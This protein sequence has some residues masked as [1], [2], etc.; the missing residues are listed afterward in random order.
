MTICFDFFE[1]FKNNVNSG[2]V[3]KII[4]FNFTLYLRKEKKRLKNPLAP[5]VR[6]FATF[7]LHKQGKYSAK[8]TKMGYPVLF[9]G[10]FHLK[11]F[12]VQVFGV[13]GTKFIKIATKI[14]F[15]VAITRRKLVSSIIVS[16]LLYCLTS[17]KRTSFVIIPLINV[18]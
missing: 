9:K 4:L 11:F 1:M 12:K 2:V 18:N 7:Y 8:L 13:F 17:S 10:T 5:F 3:S 16:N 15:N 14:N 6:K